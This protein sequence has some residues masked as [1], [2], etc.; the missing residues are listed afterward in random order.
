M[1]VGFSQRGNFSAGLAGTISVPSTFPT[2]TFGDLGN[3][4]SFAIN[5]IAATGITAS[6]QQSAINQLAY[7]LVNTGLMNKMVAVYPFVGGNAT[8]HSFN[9]KDPRNADSAFRLTFVGGFTH[10]S[11]GVLPN[12]TNGYAITYINSFTNL[13]QSN[14][15]LSFYSRTNT[16]GA[17]WEMATDNNANSYL[18]I[19]V[20]F[21]FFSGN[22]TLLQGGIGF[23]TTSTA[24]GF[25]IGSK[26]SFSER[27][28]FRN[29]VLNT[30][31]TTTS[32]VTQLQSLNIPLF[33]RNTGA[34]SGYSAKEC[35]FASIGSGLSQAECATLYRIVQT[36][37][38]TLG[39]QI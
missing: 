11:T 34:I 38:T 3:F 24:Q 18:Q 37:Q 23:Q 4:N 27:F 13:V 6:D 17:S 32:D 30:S 26:T 16:V 36:Y 9:L 19:R 33:A 29:G 5:F 2:R 1:F 21:Q 39:R 7:D 31:V 28:G 20:G 25:W 8:A 15:H 35:A 10:S 12:G 14:H 22:G